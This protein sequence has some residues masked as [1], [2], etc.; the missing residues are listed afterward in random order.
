MADDPIDYARC[1][2]AELR[3]VADHIDRIRFPERA[4]RVDDEIRRR[5]SVPGDQQEPI[6]FVGGALWGS[7]AYFGRH[8]SWPFAK[9]TISPHELILRIAIFNT[10]FTF[11]PTH[12]TSILD[13]RALFSRTFVIDHN[14]RDYPSEI[15]F[16]SGQPD[17]LRQSLVERLWT[18]KG[19]GLFSI[20]ADVHDG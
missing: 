12:V 13:R 18:V 9:L 16:S 7:S 11:L 5:R 15:L 20:S 14:R 1:T 17:L 6:V 4:N 19:P 8:A 10:T 2:L 3:D